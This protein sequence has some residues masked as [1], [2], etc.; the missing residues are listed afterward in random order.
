MAWLGT[1]DATGR[2]VEGYEREGKLKRQSE[3]TLWTVGLEAI[4]TG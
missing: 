4:P 1:D 2:W 3:R